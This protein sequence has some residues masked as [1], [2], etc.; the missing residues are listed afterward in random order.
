MLFNDAF[1]DGQPQSRP[2]SGILCRKKRVKDPREDIGR[3]PVAGVAHL[4]LHVPIHPGHM[5][6]QRA[7]FVHGMDAVHDEIDQDLGHLIRIRLDRR[8]RRIE[9]LLNHDVLAGESFPEHFET[10]LDC[11]A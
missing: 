11:L 9:R 6:P 2:L 10:V 5:H 7:S 3:D 8:E 4:Q 1:D